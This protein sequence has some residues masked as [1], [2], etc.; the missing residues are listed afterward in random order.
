M[1][2]I[3]RADGNGDIGMGHLMRCSAIAD[4]FE[5][6]GGKTCFLVSQDSDLSAVKSLGHSAY[7]LKK[8]GNMG[9]DVDEAIDWIRSQHAD[10]LLIDSYRVDAQY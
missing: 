8:I 2:L 5:K 9:W 10:R 1:Y 7:Q 4:E 6:A 3:I